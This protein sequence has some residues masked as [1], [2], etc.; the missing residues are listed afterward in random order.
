MSVVVRKKGDDHYTVF[1]KGSPEKL[2]AMADRQSVPADYS[3]VLER[4]GFSMYTLFF[5]LSIETP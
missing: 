5:I 3:Q 1:V 4:Y 2:L